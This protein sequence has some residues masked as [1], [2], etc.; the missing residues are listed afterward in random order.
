MPKG[1]IGY[2]DQHYNTLE[3]DKSVFEIIKDV[4]PSWS[5]AEIR[6]HLND[7]LFKKTKK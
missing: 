5:H 2:L 3:A 6:N 7:F 1:D 4:V